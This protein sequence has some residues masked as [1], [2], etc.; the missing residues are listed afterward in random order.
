MQQYVLPR[1]LCSRLKNGDMTLMG[2]LH[3]LANV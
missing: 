2:C 3:N 1:E